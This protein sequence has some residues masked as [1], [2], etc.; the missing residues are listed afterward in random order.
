[1][2]PEATIATGDSPA[3]PAQPGE[4]IVLRAPRRH[5]PAVGRIWAHYT[6]KSLTHRLRGRRIDVLFYPEQP[7]SMH[8]VVWKICAEL[9]LCITH[10]ASQRTSLAV[11]WKDATFIRRSE[12]TPLVTSA[13]TINGACLDISKANVSRHFSAVFGYSYDVDPLT[14]CGPCLEKSNRNAR[15]DG[16]IVSARGAAPRPGA[17]YQRVINNVVGGNLVEDIRVPV[18]NGIVPFAYLKRRS[19]AARFDSN[20]NHTVRLCSAKEIL[21]AEEIRNI[22]TFATSIGL[23]YGELD[24]LRDRDDGRIYVVDANKTPAGPSYRLPGAELRRAVKMLA[25]A[26]RDQ[27]LA[28]AER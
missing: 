12:A 2:A 7:G 28:G 23:D 11:L 3:D 6:A 15:H 22:G 9:G 19:M 13:R 4:R 26:F 25:F 10:E 18:V 8:Y 17:V 14:Y 21:S 1:M 20:R 24:V 5:L 16:R 27:F